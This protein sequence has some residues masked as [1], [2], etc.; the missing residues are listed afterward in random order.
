MHVDAD[1]QRVIDTLAGQAGAAAPLSDVARRRRLT[2]E[3][4]A[5]LSGRGDPVADVQNVRLGASGREVRAR[6]YDA[7]GATD[8]PLLLFAHGGCWIT[9]DLDTHDA[10]CRALAHRA[11]CVVVAVDYR[12]APEHQYPAALEDMEAA[13]SHLLSSRRL[14]RW[15]GVRIALAGDSAG[16]TLAASLAQ[17]YRHVGLTAQ[18]LIYPILDSSQ[19]TESYRRYGTGLTLSAAEMSL[20]WD[21]YCPDPDLRLSA[22]AAPLREGDLAGLP[23]TAIVVAEY[24]V[25]A[26]E[27]RHYARRLRAAAVPVQIIVGRHLAHGFIRMEA[28]VPAAATILD[29]CGS[30]LRRAFARGRRDRRA[31]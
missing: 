23:P 4:A 20:C 29:R 30:F 21:L 18:L 31:A 12:L 14:G 22:A 5:W 1:M 3:R 7:T 9:G 11:G 6:V 28:H 13:L 16:G 2:R 26:D 19:E 17:R 25:L 15:D 24:D 10:L 27:G 8:Q